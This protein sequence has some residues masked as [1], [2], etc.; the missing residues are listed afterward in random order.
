VRLGEELP[1][2]CERCGYSLHGLQAI[3]CAHCDILQFACPECGYHQ[4]I[5]TLRPAAQ[6]FIGRIRAIALVGIVFFKLNFFGWAMVA[7][8]AMGVNWIYRYGDNDGLVIRHLDLEM[9]LSFIALAV[10][11][12][13]IGR[14]LVLRWRHGVRVG[15]VLALLQLI[16]ISLG[17]FLNA[18]GYWR[19]GAEALRRSTDFWLIIAWT[20]GT[21]VVA[22]TAVWPIWAAM[23]WALLPR[24]AGRA[25]L[26]WQT[27]GAADRF[28]S[29]L[30]R[31]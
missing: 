20:C 8:F 13:T 31:Q 28:S 6:R 14:M 9:L 2:F 3:R 26:E 15:L 24:D 19:Y 18:V 23:V 1:V 4:P 30:A 11:Y 21:T 17:A 12:G 22:A 25:L 29:R 16:A 5:N 27:S 10:P 7:W